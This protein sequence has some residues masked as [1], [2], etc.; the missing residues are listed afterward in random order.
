MKYLF[1]FEAST[2]IA[3]LF[4]D[5][6]AFLFFVLA[7]ADVA[8]EHRQPSHARQRHL[9]AVRSQLRSRSNSKRLVRLQLKDLNPLLWFLQ[10]EC[11]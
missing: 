7:I 6:E 8:D 9:Q 4:I 1:I 5:A 3:E 2:D 10:N 11:I